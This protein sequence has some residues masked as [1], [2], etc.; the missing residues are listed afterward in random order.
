M[1]KESL[2]NSINIHQNDQLFFDELKSS[3][4]Y[5]TYK[6]NERSELE[7]DEEDEAEVHYMELEDDEDLDNLPYDDK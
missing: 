4:F 7:D 5:S 2:I 1:Q 3:I 6:N